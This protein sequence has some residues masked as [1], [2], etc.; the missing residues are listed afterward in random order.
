MLCVVVNISLGTHATNNKLCNGIHGVSYEE[1]ARRMGAAQHSQ[2][3]QELPVS[4][5][6]LSEPV[7]QHRSQGRSK[8]TLVEAL[9]RDTG[10]QSASKLTD[11]MENC[12]DWKQRPRERDGNSLKL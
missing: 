8:V 4:K 3:H 12:K 9:K 11:Q 2:R 6:V 7:H 1:E 10:A 5:L